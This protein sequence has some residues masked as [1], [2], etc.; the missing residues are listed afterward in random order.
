[1]Q[2]IYNIASSLALKVFWKDLITVLTHTLG[3]NHSISALKHKYRRRNLIL[4]FGGVEFWPKGVSWSGCGEKLN[5][6][7]AVLI[8]DICAYRIYNELLPYHFN[9]NRKSLK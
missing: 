4:D 9:L 5:T 6:T 2:Y 3:S 8:R 1:M 7:K